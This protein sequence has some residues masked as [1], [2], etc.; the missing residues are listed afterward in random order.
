MIH[1]TRH[2][3][4]R[5]REGGGEEKGGWGGERKTSCQAC[6]QETARQPESALLF[7]QWPLSTERKPGP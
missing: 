6:C 2:R 4:E 7:S 1:N 5:E 3:G